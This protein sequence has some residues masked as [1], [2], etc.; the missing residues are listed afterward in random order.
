MS[1]FQPC[2][3]ALARDVEDGTTVK[4]SDAVDAEA[5]ICGR[6]RT[7]QCGEIRFGA[8]AGEKRKTLGEGSL[9]SG[10]GSLGSDLNF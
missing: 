10:E 9:G 8:A 7:N 5:L 6:Q 3:M 4:G 1:D 2:E